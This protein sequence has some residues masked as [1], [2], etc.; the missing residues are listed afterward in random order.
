MS[1]FSFTTKI[2]KNFKIKIL[3]YAVS[4]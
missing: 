4:G 2:N 3:P 1:I